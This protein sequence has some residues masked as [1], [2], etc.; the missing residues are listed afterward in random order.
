MAERDVVGLHAQHAG[1]APL[2]PDRHVAEPDR[3]V[4]G[5][6]QRAGDDA[7]RV[8]EVDDPG[9]GLGVR[10]H[11]VGDVQ[12]D[13]HGAQGLREAARAGRLLP[14]AVH[15]MRPGL[16]AAAGICPPTRNWISTTSASST[17]GRGRS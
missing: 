1:E 15:L 13:R 17:P 2:E 10:A 14:D 12:D 9:V 5:L 4:A 6:E 16:I 3:T 8:G 7:D 11:G